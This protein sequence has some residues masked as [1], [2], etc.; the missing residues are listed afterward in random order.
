MSQ[1]TIKSTKPTYKHRQFVI[2]S[3]FRE[4]PKR[5]ISTT[6]YQIYF[7]GILRWLIRGGQFTDSLEHSIFISIAFRTTR[8]HLTKHPND[9]WLIVD[10][11]EMLANARK[12]FRESSR[13]G[14]RQCLVSK[15]GVIFGSLI[16]IRVPTFKPFSKFVW[17]HVGCLSFK[18]THRK[19]IFD[20]HTTRIN[21]IS[22]RLS[23]VIS[24]WASTCP[25]TSRTP[26]LP[27]SPTVVSISLSNWMFSL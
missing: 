6:I 11:F 20:R 25:S 9:R 22:L 7:F 26:V 16:S 2:Q 27:S 21:V 13:R 17:S 1:F 19:H 5:R 24:Y 12:V 10:T 15:P 18:Y 4:S 23:E 8:S 3:S 14:P